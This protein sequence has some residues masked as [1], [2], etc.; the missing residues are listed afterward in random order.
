MTF[1]ENSDDYGLTTVM[2]AQPFHLIVD[3]HIRRRRRPPTAVRTGRLVERQTG[4]RVEYAQRH[5][6][7][8]V[9]ER[10]KRCRTVGGL[11]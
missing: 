6:P 7:P 11:C 9:F 8:A 5:L 2:R 1:I 3:G 4:Q 10:A